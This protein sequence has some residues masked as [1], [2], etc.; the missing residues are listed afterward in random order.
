MLPPPDRQTLRSLTTRQ[1][2]LNDSPRHNEEDEQEEEERHV[3]ESESLRGRGWLVRKE[4][5]RE[6]KAELEGVKKTSQEN[7]KEGEGKRIEDRNR[8]EEEGEGGG[9]KCR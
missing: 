8:E 2:Y 5:G 4:G 1:H 6:E 3:R 7:G 9:G